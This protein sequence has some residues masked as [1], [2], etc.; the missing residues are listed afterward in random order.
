MAIMMVGFSQTNEDPIL[1]DVDSKP[2]WKGCELQ[3]DEVAKA[4]C[5]ENKLAAFFNDFIIYPEKARKR[6]TEGQVVVQF[7]VE[8]DGSISNILV[9]HDIGDG[10]AEEVIRAIQHLPRLI[11]GTNAGDPVRVLYKAP[12]NF[13][14]K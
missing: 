5:F 13:V 10:C 9:I 11:P 12:F 8:K 6:K 4:I 7:V 1:V 3:K 14:L 2:T